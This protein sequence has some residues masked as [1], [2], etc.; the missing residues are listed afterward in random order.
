VDTYWIG[1]PVLS[2][3]TVV[4]MQHSFSSTSSGQDSEDMSHPFSTPSA[5]DSESKDL[6]LENNQP[7]Q[8]FLPL[9]HDFSS[10]ESSK[11]R[12]QQFFLRLDR[13]FSTEEQSSVSSSDGGKSQESHVHGNS[14][15]MM[16]RIMAFQ[17]RFLGE[18]KFESDNGVEEA[19]SD[20]KG[21]GV[22]GDDSAQH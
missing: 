7:Q 21:D 2:Q 20:D 14:H 1:S 3:Q 6:Q 12:Q 16:Q 13:K 22:E 11:S 4:D 5:K 10:D 18:Y 8:N 19:N 17:S 9:D 15:S